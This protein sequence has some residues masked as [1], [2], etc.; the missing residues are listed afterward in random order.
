[1]HRNEALLGIFGYRTNEDGSE[2]RVWVKR[3]D[4]S[5]FCVHNAA[6][7]CKGCVEADERLQ[8]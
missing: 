4:G 1:M 6:N 2:T 3:A 7:V 5:S 8:S